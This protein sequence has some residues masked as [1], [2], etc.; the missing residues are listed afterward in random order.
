MGLLGKP[1]I[2]GSTPIRLADEP[3][4]STGVPTAK[5]LVAMQMKCITVLMVQK[6]GPMMW[7]GA[8]TV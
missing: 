4:I 7:D 3:R 6:S 5:S 8:K 2:L 1:T